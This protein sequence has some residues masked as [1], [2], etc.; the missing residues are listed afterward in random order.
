[1]SVINF[2]GDAWC[3]R[4]DE[5]EP[6]EDALRIAD[7]LGRLTRERFPESTIVIG[8]DTRPLSTAIAQEMG[9]V[10]ASYG[11]A[12]HVSASHCPA[13]VLTEAVRRDREAVAGIMLT[14]GNK[15]ADYFG[16]RIC[17]ADGSAATMED[18][19]LIESYIFPELPAARGEA[20]PVDL[21]TPYLER[22]SSLVEGDKIAVSSPLVV[23]DPMYGAQTSYAGRVFT[24]LGA[25]VME[26][27]SDGAED[28]AGVHP[29]AAEPWIDDC[30][31]A[32]IENRADYG[33]AIDGAGERIALVDEQGN[34]V[35]PHKT[36]ALLMEYLVVCR[37]RG[38]RMVAPI[39]VSSIVRRQAER[40][41]L[42]LTI[43]PVGYAW[44]REEMALG[45][46]L[47]AGDA[48]GGI[49]IPETGLDRD[50][51][52]AAVM[53]MDA[54]AR[55]GR[56]LS[57]I[58]SEL[59]EKLGHMEYGRRELSLGAGEAQTLRVALPGINP[60]SIAGL[61]VEGVSHPS[62]CLRLALPEGAW[63]LIAPSPSGPAALLAAEASTRAIRDDLLSA[64]AELARAPLSGV[65]E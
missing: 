54:I 10:I 30:E 42:S 15:P 29:E 4:V 24:S 12:A 46:T 33:I 51:L 48:V 45:D 23:C 61:N 65:G 26:I 58:V 63:A 60:P 21:M 27:H 38:G 7:A 39:F 8:Y 57:A 9:E 18:T 32:V 6:H 14:A 17:S 37:G 1:M 53:L 36:L 44:M 28:F 35:S 59:D 22:V 31:Q 16:I 52:G 43:T 40:L 19:D 13:C 2:L 25:R 56:R 64:A 62:H 55:D 5:G 20:E 49:G 50:A 41:G 34:Y 3:V 47:C 11:I